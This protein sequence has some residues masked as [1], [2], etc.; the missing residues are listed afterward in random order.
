MLKVAFFH[1]SKT[2]EASKDRVIEFKFNM[3]YF[4]VRNKVDL[5]K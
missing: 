1:P 3:N 4:S 5:F 2:K